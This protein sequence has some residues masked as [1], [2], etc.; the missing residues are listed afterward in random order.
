MIVR[1]EPLWLPFKLPAG[2]SQHEDARLDLVQVTRVVPAFD[3]RHN[4]KGMH[5]TFTFAFGSNRADLQ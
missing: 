5:H 2:A 3:T 4:L 1:L